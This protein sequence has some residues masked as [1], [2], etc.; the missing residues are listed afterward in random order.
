[1]FFQEM[2]HQNLTYAT[3]LFMM[4]REQMSASLLKIGLVDRKQEPEAE[5]NVDPIGLS[6]EVGK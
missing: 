4:L 3:H 6:V 1:M 2:W 5:T